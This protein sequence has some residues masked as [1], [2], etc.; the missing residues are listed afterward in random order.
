M[1]HSYLN[2][3][4]PQLNPELESLFLEIDRRSAECY[5]RLEEVTR[6]IGVLAG[7]LD[8]KDESVPIAISGREDSL[9]I[10]MRNAFVT[11]QQVAARAKPD[12]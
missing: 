2:G 5:D 9:V 10:N 12:K 8:Q 1:A 3:T 6:K 11:A 4:R 7:F